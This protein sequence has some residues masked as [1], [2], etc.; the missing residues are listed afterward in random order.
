MWKLIINEWEKLFRRTGTIVMFGLVFL[1]VCGISGILKY[2][3]TQN[4]PKENPDW[5][6]ELQLQLKDSRTALEQIGKNNANMKMFYEREIAINEYR[7]EHNIAPQQKEHV[8]SFVRDLEQIITF[9]GIFMIIVAAGMVSSEFSWGTI[10]LLLIRPMSR[11]KILLSKYLTVLL[12][13][14]TLLAF[15]FILSTIAGFLLFG[16]PETNV[17]HLA[18]SNGEVIQRSIVVQLIV[19]YLLSSIDVLMLATMAFM[20]STVFRNSSLAIG[21]SLFL[22][23][24]GGTATTLLAGRFEWAKYILFANTNLSV[25]FDGVPPVEGMTLTFSIAMLILYYALFQILSFWVFAKRDV[26]A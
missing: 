25:Y 12:F 18:Y 2:E 15:L 9:I 10:K 1:M 8:W 3:E 14:I 7:L 13:G 17:P 22:L 4:P 24:M 5:K 26:A 19:E 16:S 21:L 20:V 23:F 11:A 6:Q